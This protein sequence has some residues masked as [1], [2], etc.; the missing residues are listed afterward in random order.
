MHVVVADPLRVGHETSYHPG[1]ANLRM[2]DIVVINKVDSALPDDLLTLR[3]TIET[4]NED[5]A[6]VEARSPIAV[7]DFDSLKGKRVIV[8]EDGPT[9][10]HGEMSFGAGV[11]A[12]TRAGAELV[13]PRPWAVGSIRDVYERYPHVGALV[14]AMGY[15][16]VQRAELA[17]TIN[18]SDA[19]V[20]LVATPIDLRKVCD[21][22]KPGLR[23]LYELEDA[24]TPSL[25]ELLTERLGL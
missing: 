25:A 11:V 5:A 18:A 13:D 20:V 9:L 16:E 15:S 8:I 3:K 19:D 2:A 14:P 22:D 7:E 6:I 24:S 10:T 4:V 1:E 12:A 23:V 17:E 21:I